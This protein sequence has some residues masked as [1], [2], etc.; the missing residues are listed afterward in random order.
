MKALALGFLF[1]CCT[2]HAQQAPPPKEAASTQPKPRK[3]AAKL[4]EATISGVPY[5]QIDWSKPVG[6]A[7]AASQPALNQQEFD[8]FLARL[9]SSS[10]PPKQKPTLGAVDAWR[11]R[12]CQEEAA[13]APTAVGVHHGMRLCREKFDQ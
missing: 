4:P 8:A 11:F 12:K 6:R 3:A 9:E 5:N 1:A 2:T 7:V 10:I 13:Q